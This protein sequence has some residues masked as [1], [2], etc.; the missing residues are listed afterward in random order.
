MTNVVAVDKS[1]MNQ[2]LSKLDQIEEK[3][4]FIA[5]KIKQQDSIM[6]EIGQAVKV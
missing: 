4:E 5:R 6:K 2:V 1:I 3:V